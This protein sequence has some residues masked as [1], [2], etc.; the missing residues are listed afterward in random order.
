MIKKGFTIAE[1]I[2]VIAIIGILFGI[3]GNTYR[4][5]RQ[6]YDFTDSQQQILSL[7]NTARNYAT[8]SRATYDKNK[9]DNPATPNDER[10]YIPP[11]GYG[12]SIE[13]ATKKFVLFANTKVDG[14]SINQYDTGAGGDVVEETYT[15]PNATVFDSLLQPR[16]STGLS[17]AVIIFRPPLAEVTITDNA[18]PT[19]AILN[20]LTLGLYSAETPFIA[21]IGTDGEPVKDEGG[22]VIMIPPETA[23]RYITISKVAGFPELIIG[24]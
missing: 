10:L 13:R 16:S 9:V 3:A 6:R 23:K 19:L 20:E 14:N 12:V 15:L 21:Q 4:N 11:E 18:V 2:L 8:T 1:L 22:K 7:I 17:K 24:K 5:Q